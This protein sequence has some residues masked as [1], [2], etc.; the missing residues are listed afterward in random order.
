M[1]YEFGSESEL[2][3]APKDACRATLRLLGLGPERRH[4]AAGRLSGLKGVL[5]ARGSS[6][7]G[8]VQVEFDGAAVSTGAMALELQAAGLRLEAA[9]RIRVDGMHCQSCV[10]TIEGQMGLLPGVSHVRVRLEDASALIVHRPLL[11]SQQELRDKIEDLGFV[12][13]LLPN[14]LEEPDLSSWQEEAPQVSA[15]TVTI[16]IE[17]MTCGSCVQSIEGRVGQV[18][19]V[20]SITVSLKEAKGTVTFDPGL[21]GPERLR[22][23][24]EDMGFVASLEGRSCS[25]LSN[26]RWN[27]S[28]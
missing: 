20:R 17:G 5:R 2:C 18:G 10:Q 28:K 9:L 26:T 14:D 4:E 12:A 16:W 21:T 24:I 11:V 1:A 7:G 6:S 23:A 3:P 13:T 19:G 22:E 8:W 25:F 15:Q 27:L